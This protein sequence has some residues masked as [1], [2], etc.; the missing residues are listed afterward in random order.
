MV[1]YG[2]DRLAPFILQQLIKNPTLVG[3]STDPLSFTD[4]DLLER[5]LSYGRSGFQLQFMLDT[6][7][8]LVPACH[9][10]DVVFLSSAAMPRGMAGKSP[11]PS[12]PASKPRTA[13]AAHFRSR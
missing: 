9:S 10:G 6:R 2:S 13:R 8:C 12:R 1:N 7:L 4:D 3:T 11:E 5:E